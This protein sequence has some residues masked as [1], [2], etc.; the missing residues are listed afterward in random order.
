MYNSNY[1]YNHG[2]E[3][4]RLQDTLKTTSIIGDWYVYA[5]EISGFRHDVD[6][7]RDFLGY[8]AAYSGNYLPVFRDNQEDLAFF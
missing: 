6:E 1:F 2:R 3:Y 8:Y 5:C 4:V 7:I